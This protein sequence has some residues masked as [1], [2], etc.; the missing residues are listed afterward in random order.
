MCTHRVARNSEWLS[1]KEGRKGRRRKGRREGGEERRREGGTEKK[2]ME[3]GSG[4][5]EGA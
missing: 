1:G 3:K 2:M 5:E 4:E